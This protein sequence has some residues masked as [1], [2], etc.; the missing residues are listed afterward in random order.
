MPRETVRVFITGGTGFF[1]KSMLDYRRRHPEWKW[2]RAK[3]VILSR[4]PEKFVATHPQLANQDGVSFISGDIRD[5]A[6]PEGDFDAIIHSATSAVTTLADEEMM[7][8][9]LDGTRRVI[10]FAVEKGCRKLLFTSSGA[11]Y[12]PRT[13]P[14]SENDEC[15]PVT[16]YGK[17]KLQAERML[18]DSGLDVK[19]ARCFAFAGKHLPR[20]IHYAIGNFIQNCLDGQPIVINGD[21]TPLR[22][23]MY[24]DDL[25]EWLFA[26][27]ERGESGRPYNV[28]SDKALSI[29]ELAASVRSILG[30]K[31]EIV[32]KG[33]PDSA[34]LP[35]VYVPCIERAKYELGLELKTSIESSIRRMAGLSEWKQL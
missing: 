2:A 26:I 13:S 5:F 1:G 18:L 31:N 21:G 24:A 33:K 29:R 30:V 17:G 4:D 15:L 14:A 11:V 22:S 28:G 35:S 20:T 7:S 27:L 32:V 19:I 8:V 9:I 6:F 25:V 3:W 16:A 12:G 23:Y 10:D 34:K